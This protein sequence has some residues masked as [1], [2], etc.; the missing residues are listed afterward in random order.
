MTKINGIFDAA[1][2][3]LV[4][5]ALAAVVGICFVQ[6]V[7][8]YLFSASFTWAEE[9]S[10]ILLLWAT[11]GAACLGVKKDLHLRVCILDDRLTPRLSIILRLALNSLAILFMVVIAL[12]SKIVIKAMANITLMSLPSLPMNV[13]YTCVPVG[14]VMMIY[15]LL[16]SIAGDFKNLRSLGH[17]EKR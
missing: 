11:W 14:C 13:L 12:T 17:L 9:V 5:A 6:V 10:I 7:A 16:R 4:A 1:I 3:Y 15:Y 8:R 2:F